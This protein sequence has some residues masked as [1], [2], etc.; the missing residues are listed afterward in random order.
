MS[1][2]EDPDDG[3][4]YIFYDDNQRLYDR[5]GAF[6]ITETP[7]HLPE[8]CRNTKQIHEAV[9]VFYESDNVPRCLGPEGPEPKLYG[10]SSG[11]NEAEEV[12]KLVDELVKDEGVDPGDIAILTRRSRDRSAW[13]NPHR[14]EAWSSNLGAEG[15][16]GEGAVLDRPQLQ[17]TRTSRHYRLRA[18][19]HADGRGSRVLVRG[20]F[21]RPS[22]TLRIRAAGGLTTPWVSG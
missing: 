16:R 4:L 22:A 7:F 12:Q 13:K 2:L 14:R 21:T 18:G 8:N 3:I 15:E 19:R 17:G 6:P 20:P 11:E 10:V 5:H 9:M 1:L